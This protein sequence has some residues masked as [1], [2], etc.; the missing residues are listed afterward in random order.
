MLQGHDAVAAMEDEAKKI[1]LLGLARLQARTRSSRHRL[2]RSSMLHKRCSM[3]GPAPGRRSRSPGCAL[4]A[5]SV[6]ASRRGAA[7]AGS[8]SSGVVAFDDML[9]NLH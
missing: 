9:F 3:S 2:S 7:R 6:G 5:G 4:V 1:D 8:A